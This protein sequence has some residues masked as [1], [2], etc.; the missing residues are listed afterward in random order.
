MECVGEPL[1]ID[2][3]YPV[4]VTEEGRHRRL[5]AGESVGYGTRVGFK[6]HKGYQLMK[7]NLSCY[8]NE[9]LSDTE[10]DTNCIS[11]V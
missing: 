11:K 1:E 7:C 9:S 5:E 10:L 4:V 2:N 8:W 6:C 3:G